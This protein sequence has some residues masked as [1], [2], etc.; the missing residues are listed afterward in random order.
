[1]ILCFMASQDVGQLRAIRGSSRLLNATALMYQHEI[2]WGA[3]NNPSSPYSTVHR[4]YH[5]LYQPVNPGLQYFLGMSRRCEIAKELSIALADKV[6]ETHP[7]L[8]GVQLKTASYGK[9]VRNIEPYILALADF[10]E[11]YRDGLA[12]YANHT[13]SPQIPFDAVE[14]SVLS[15]KYNRETVYRICSLY[16]MLKLILDRD[17]RNW[18]VNGVLRKMFVYHDVN[19]VSYNDSVGIFTFGGIEAVKDIVAEPDR[20]CYP[21][22]I[23]RHSA[24]AFPY[25]TWVFLNHKLPPSTLPNCWNSDNQRPHRPQAD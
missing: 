18:E 5:G 23:Y 17:L 24:R 13:T 10:F 21:L 20:K 7:S 1:M 12:S 8:P 9:F 2:V 3:L 4:L 22:I 14:L 19:R 11:C 6:V 16:Y 15:S 25:D